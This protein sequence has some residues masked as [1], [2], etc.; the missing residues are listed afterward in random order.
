MSGSNTVFGW[1]KMT[2]NKS[3]VFQFIRNLGEFDGSP[4]CG[5]A[6]HPVFP[7]VGPCR[8]GSGCVAA[9]QLLSAPVAGFGARDPG[10][11]ESPFVHERAFRTPQSPQ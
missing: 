6:D 9:E 7:G 10:C 11:S 2:P 1:R 8:P 5:N 3:V 4:L